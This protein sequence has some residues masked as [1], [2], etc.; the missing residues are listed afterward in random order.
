MRQVLNNLVDNALRHTASGEDITLGAE[1][2]KENMCLWVQNTGAGIAAEHLNHVFERFWRADVSRSC[3]KG[4]GLG[5]AIVAAIAE[6][7]GGN[8]EVSSTSGSGT[9]FTVCLPLYVREDFQETLRKG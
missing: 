4:S 6:A 3:S 8:V 5:L 1:V 2:R 7:H 9:T